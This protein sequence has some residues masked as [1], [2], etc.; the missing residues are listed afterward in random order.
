MHRSTFEPEFKNFLST[1]RLSQ[2]KGVLI[3]KKCVVQNYPIQ[4]FNG[5]YIALKTGLEYITY[6]VSITFAVKKDFSVLIER[7][8]VNAA[9]CL[10]QEIIFLAQLK[11]T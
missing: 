10:N 4:T 8:Q 3:K 2:K 6:H 11:L 9:T 5:H 7:C 1:P